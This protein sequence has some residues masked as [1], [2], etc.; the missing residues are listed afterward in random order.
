MEVISSILKDD[1]PPIGTYVEDFP[2]ELERIIGK[3]L[4][5]DLNERYQHIKD[6]WID[7]K[8]LN[9][10]LKFVAKLSHTADI[11]SRSLKK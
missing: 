7:L 4:R 9:D 8:D 10:E 1:P 11:I 3:T 6:L 5:K 2:G